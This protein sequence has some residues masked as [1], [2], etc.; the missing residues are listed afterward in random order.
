MLIRS[1]LFRHLPRCVDLAEEFQCIHMEP[2]QSMLHLQLNNRVCQLG[3]STWDVFS[4]SDAILR[5]RLTI[6]RDN[7]P[8]A[9][10][11]G[12][13]LNTFPYMVWENETQNSPSAC[14]A[15]CQLFGFDSAGLE[16]GSQCFCGDK[17]NIYV[18]SAP[19]T[20]TSKT[21]FH[22][23]SLLPGPLFKIKNICRRARQL[24]VCIDGC[25]L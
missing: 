1:F 2:Q 8:S 14:I 20:S 5:T 10:D 3:G 13:I 9:E 6:I 11:A 21:Y 15:Q 22:T 16:Y 23:N 12:E 18:A 7:I 19:S 17:Q 4:K 24:S 25:L